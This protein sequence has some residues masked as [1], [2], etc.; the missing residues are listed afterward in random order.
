MSVSA[1]MNYLMERTCG[2]NSFS[3]TAIGLLLGIFIGW[4]CVSAWQESGRIKCEK[5]LPR[6]QQCEQLWVPQPAR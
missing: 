4:G 3:D 5:D 2:V 1:A 6:T